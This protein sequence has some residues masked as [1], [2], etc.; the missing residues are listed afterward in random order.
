MRW[1]M[2]LVIIR[3]RVYQWPKISARFLLLSFGW[4]KCN[5]T[6]K[7]KKYR[8]ISRLIRVYFFVSLPERHLSN[9][10]LINYNDNKPSRLLPYQFS[11]HIAID[12]VSMLKWLILNSKRALSMQPAHEQSIRIQK[13]KEVPV[14]IDY[15]IEHIMSLSME[16]CLAVANSLIACYDKLS[17][18]TKSLH[19]AWHS[20][21]RIWFHYFLK[22]QIAEMK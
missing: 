10:S 22:W 20:D 14:N 18:V 6:N 13:D 16:F 4:V 9:L 21:K 1:A 17:S 19:F 3:C 7:K 2:N 11:W 12:T 8:D 5:D 15:S